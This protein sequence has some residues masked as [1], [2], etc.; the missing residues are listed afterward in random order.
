MISVSR[1][2]R[3]L[4]M[5]DGCGNLKPIPPSCKPTSGP[6][7]EMRVTQSTPT[8]ALARRGHERCLE[9]AGLRT[10][11]LVEPN[12][13]GA[14]I[15]MASIAVIANLLFGYGAQ[16]INSEKTLV[17]VLPFVLSVSFLLIADMECPRGGIIRV[18]PQNLITL[19]NS[20]RAQ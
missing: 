5:S 18:N 6:P 14:W 16:N 3:L 7:S 15:L 19:A 4:A 11:R 1:S 20:L 17:V 10:S 12:P 13:D 2:I 9:F 8:I